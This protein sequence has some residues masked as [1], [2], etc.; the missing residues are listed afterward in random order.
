VERSGLS[1]YLSNASRKHGGSPQGYDGSID[2]LGVKK[3]LSE[4]QEYEGN[5][6]SRTKMRVVG[7]ASLHRCDSRWAAQPKPD[8]ASKPDPAALIRAWG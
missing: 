6:S 8:D 2:Q 1:E 4:A 3:L 5:L 7:L